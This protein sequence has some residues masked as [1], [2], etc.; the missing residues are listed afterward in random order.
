MQLHFRC[1]T[2]DTVMAKVGDVMLMLCC[3][4]VFCSD[5]IA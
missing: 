4:L 2:Q 3:K 5:E 1:T